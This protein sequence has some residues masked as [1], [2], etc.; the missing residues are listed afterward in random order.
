MDEN[1]TEVTNTYDDDGRLTARDIDR[2]TGVLGPTGEDYAYDG[3]GRM[4]S[5]TNDNSTVQRTYDTLSRLTSETQGPNPLGQNGKTITYTY[6]DG[7]N[8]SPCTYFS[9][10]QVHYTPDALGRWTKIEDA[11]SQR[12]RDLG[13]LRAGRADEESRPS[14]RHVGEPG[15]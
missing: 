10:Y 1:G 15:V 13:V 7:G 4:T 3:L 9:G 14:E 5:G 8:R 6:D 11:Q 2:A 12:P